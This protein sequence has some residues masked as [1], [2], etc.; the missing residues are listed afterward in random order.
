M[1][2]QGEEVTFENTVGT[3]L[4]QDDVLRDDITMVC[5]GNTSQSIKLLEID[6]NQV[7]QRPGA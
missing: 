7:N 2:Q 6:H 1:E 5:F 3:D 4:L